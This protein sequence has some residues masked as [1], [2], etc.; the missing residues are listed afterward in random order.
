MGRFGGRTVGTQQPDLGEFTQA[1]D[2][3]VLP[4]VVVL[5]DRQGDELAELSSRKQQSVGGCRRQV[6]VILDRSAAADRIRHAYGHRQPPAQA[7]L[8]VDDV[9]LGVSLSGRGEGDR[10]LQVGVQVQIS[11]PGPETVNVRTAQGV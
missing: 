6:R 8:H 9:A 1:E 10:G 4:D 2:E 7:H 11:L 5:R 3:G